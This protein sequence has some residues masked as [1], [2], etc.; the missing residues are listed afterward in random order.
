MFISTVVPGTIQNPITHSL[1]CPVYQKPENTKCTSAL[2]YNDEKSFYYYMC[3]SVKLEE[4]L[5]CAS[6][7]MPLRLSPAAYTYS[8]PY[9]NFTLRTVQ[10]TMKNNVLG[11][12]MGE[13]LDTV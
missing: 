10:F 6:L 1:S 4:W 5:L 12:H 8:Y 9:S 2:L 3:F 11:D 13:L 7:L